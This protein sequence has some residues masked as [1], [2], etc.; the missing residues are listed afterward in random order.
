MNPRTYVAHAHRNAFTLVEL[1]VVILI[2][3][4]I[5]GGIVIAGDMSRTAK[6]KVAMAD[7]FGYID[8]VKRFQNKYQQIPGDMADATTYWG[9]DTCPTS[10]SVVL[11]ETTCNGDNNG[12]IDT[13]RERH[14]F[15]QHLANADFINGTYSGAMV[16]AGRPYEIVGGVNA[17]SGPLQGSA[18]GV[19]VGG[20][21]TFAGDAAY[22]AL[23]YGNAM[24]LG[25]AYP[26][27]PADDVIFRPNEMKSI[28]EKYDDSLS[29][30]GI[31]VAGRW[32]TCTDAADETDF[33]VSY[34]LID[35]SI[36]CVL[37]FR[38]ITH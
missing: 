37:I 14:T 6:I 9:T 20:A 8:A 28:D 33:T 13:D 35:D 12:Y 38:N 1:A 21:G 25:S 7:T 16:N 31:I 29:A 30:R 23:D 10:S 15:W 22:Y 11:R 5:A 34:T 3:S 26:W 27:G 32:D 2:V 24:T 36:A 17:P 19:R 18:W 4:I